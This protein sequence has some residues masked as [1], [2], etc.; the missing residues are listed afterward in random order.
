MTTI[1]DC[2]PAFPVQ[3]AATWQGHGM[4]LRDYFAIHANETDIAIQAELIR[5]Q[6]GAAGKLRILPDDYRSKA[7]YMHADAM[8]AARANG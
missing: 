3:D 2:G 4:T 1:N 7:R 5:E 6:Q 8:L